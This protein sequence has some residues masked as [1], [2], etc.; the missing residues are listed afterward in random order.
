MSLPDVE[1]RELKGFLADR[2]DAIVHMCVAIARVTNV[3]IEN[4]RN[5]FHVWFASLLGDACSR[6]LGDWYDMNCVTRMEH[7]NNGSVKLYKTSRIDIVVEARPKNVC[8]RVLAVFIEIKSMRKADFARRMGPYIKARAGKITE[9]NS[10]SD[11]RYLYI[12]NK[13]NEDRNPEKSV[14][15]SRA[16]IPLMEGRNPEWIKM[17][18]MSKDSPGA[19]PDLLARIDAVVR[20]KAGRGTEEGWGCC[21][22][23]LRNTVLAYLQVYQEANGE[24]RESVLL[25]FEELGAPRDTKTRGARDNDAKAMRRY[26]CEESGIEPESMGGE[27]QA[28]SSPPSSGAGKA[29]TADEIIEELRPQFP[30]NP[31]LISFRDRITNRMMSDFPGD[32][33]V[34]AE[35][36]WDFYNQCA[37]MWE[38]DELVVRWQPYMDNLTS[39]EIKIRGVIWAFGI[40]WAEFKIQASERSSPLCR[41]LVEHWIRDNAHF[42]RL[43]LA[44]VVWL[45][46]IHPR[47]NKWIRIMFDYIGTIDR[48]SLQSI[49]ER[50]QYYQYRRTVDEAFLAD[51]DP[52][53]WA[54]PPLVDAVRDGVE[55]GEGPHQ[56]W[57]WEEGFTIG[58]SAAGCDP[59]PSLSSLILGSV[60]TISW[61]R[62]GAHP[63]VLGPRMGVQTRRGGAA[64]GGGD[65]GGPSGGYAG[66][67]SGSGGQPA[68]GGGASK[69][70]KKNA[71][72]PTRWH[73]GPA[74]TVF[75]APEW[76]VNP[77]FVGRGEAGLVVDLGEAFDGD[78]GGK[79]P[80]PPPSPSPTPRGSPDDGGAAGGGAG[81]G[82]EMD[83]IPDSQEED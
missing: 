12:I 64:G 7:A 30:P 60:V 8:N 2:I 11:L 43:P 54:K 27:S 82:G 74:G 42:P 71:V 63:P 19:I 48:G 57:F 40:W 25:K 73:V 81:G 6:V 18:E 28:S 55:D 58:V 15:W 83:V 3:V 36:R 56:R 76:F 52:E 22:Y 33:T 14:Q 75:L 24:I 34:S 80:A 78:A 45:A 79:R 23:G 72:G 13:D 62:G 1:R 9:A 26:I 69:R 37:W 5:D 59:L 4:E 29:Q 32:H 70:A 21:A 53:A 20:K 65:A 50:K 44:R 38:D 67:P 16:S 47:G 31:K 35:V 10:S 41:A 68:Q 77:I 39:S 61:P 17:P 46:T 66:G 49:R 51:S